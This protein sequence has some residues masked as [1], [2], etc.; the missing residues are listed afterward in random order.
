MDGMDDGQQHE[1]ED[2]QVSQQEQPM[3]H[4]SG[5][6]E[7]SMQ[8]GS[9]PDAPGQDIDGQV[10]ETLDNTQEQPGN[11][12]GGAGSQDPAA[13]QA[14]EQPDAAAAEEAPAADGE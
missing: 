1:N 5:Q 2:Q 11:P 14:D 9:M 4:P 12:D 7:G 8:N 10:P 3:M 13:D 6:D